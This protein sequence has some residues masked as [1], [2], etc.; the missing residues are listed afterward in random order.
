MEQSLAPTIGHGVI[1]EAGNAAI[2]LDANV[3][4]GTQWII[5]GV[6]HPPSALDP[7]GRIQKLTGI[8]FQRQ[9]SEGHKLAGF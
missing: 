2:L 7:V 1:D 6:G 3:R 9:P 5:D 8:T 4:L